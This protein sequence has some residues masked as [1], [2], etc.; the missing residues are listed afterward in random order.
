MQKVLVVVF[1]AENAAYKGLGTLK[2]LHR[3]GDISLYASAVIS[4]D[5]AGVITVKQTADEGPLGMSV[6]MLTGS[7]VGLLAG[8]AGVLTGL[9]FGALTGSLFDLQK[10]GVDLDFLDSVSEVLVPGKS[11]ILADIEETWVTPVDTVM[12]ELGGVVFRRARGDA[13]EDQLVKQR[14]A[15][16]AQLAGLVHE[17]KEAHAENKAQLEKEIAA[18]KASS[19][20]LNAKS[21]EKVLKLKNDMDA[22]IAVLRKQLADGVNARKTARIEKRIA[23]SEADLQASQARLQEALA[24][25]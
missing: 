9:T 24:Q 15:H 12:T 22:R 16:D 1:D 21:R 19:Q 11:A 3:D 13:I 5:A 6:G 10:S 25:R 4:K 17:L 18:L 2:N 23:Q 8:P 20:A 7:M 14:G